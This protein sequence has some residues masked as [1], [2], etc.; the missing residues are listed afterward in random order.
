MGEEA[1]GVQLYSSDLGFGIEFTLD[2]VREDVK[3]TTCAVGLGPQRAERHIDFGPATVEATT[4]DQK[5]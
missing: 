4:D 3:H 1:L 5:K 2:L